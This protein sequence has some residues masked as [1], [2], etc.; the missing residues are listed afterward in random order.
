MTRCVG[1]NDEILEDITSNQKLTKLNLYAL[2]FL[3][4]KFFNS[5]TCKLQFL[6]LC[7][8]TTIVNDTFI[9]NADKF[10]E[11]RYLNLVFMF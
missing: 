7:G 5:M 8:N 10:S 6:D 2:P 4:C 3:E 11:L 9:N 1:L